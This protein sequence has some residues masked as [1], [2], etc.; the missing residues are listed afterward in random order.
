[1]NRT[2]AVSPLLIVSLLCAPVAA[3]PPVPGPP[4]DNQGDSTPVVDLDAAEA[5]KA[6][7]E[8]VAAY[9]NTDY[10]LAAERF[11]RAQLLKP[12]PE[13]LLK[14]AQRQLK[15]GLYVAAATHFQAYLTQTDRDNA[16]ARNGLDDAKTQV[17]EVAILAPEGTEI[18]V[19]QTPVGVAPLAQPLYL[20]TGQHEV[21]A[22]ERRETIQVGAGQSSTVDLLSDDG[23]TGSALS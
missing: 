9:Q 7:E 10:K 15:A 18:V 13:V 11:G 5:R 6:F 23:S 19:D 21:V 12:H 3:Q 2:R 4:T 8:G 1:M 20:V 22:G 17:A 16:T 14:R